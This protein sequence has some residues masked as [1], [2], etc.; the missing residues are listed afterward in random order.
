MSPVCRGCD[1]LLETAGRD[2][3]RSSGAPVGSLSGAPRCSEQPGRGRC[4]GQAPV[5][6][7]NSGFRGC[8]PH[9]SLTAT[10]RC[11]GLSVP[12]EETGSRA[13]VTFSPEHTG[14]QEACI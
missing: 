4:L 5:C 10:V 8:R 9:G 3:C 2:G 12:G 11:Q 14:R 6:T 13:G 1:G 7:E